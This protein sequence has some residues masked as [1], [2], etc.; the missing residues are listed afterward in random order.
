[1]TYE[2]YAELPGINAT[3][4]KAGVKS[5]LHMHHCMTGGGHKETPALRWGKLVHLA[6]LEPGSPAGGRQ[7][8]GRAAHRLAPPGQDDLRIAAAYLLGAEGDGLHG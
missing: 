2:E 7:D 1:M 4:I 3:S 6:V 8:V 5:M